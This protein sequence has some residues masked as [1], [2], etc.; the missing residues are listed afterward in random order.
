MKAGSGRLTLILLTE[1]EQ[2]WERRFW[3]PWHQDDVLTPRAL[4][5]TSYREWDEETVSFSQHHINSVRAGAK[6]S[7]H[8]RH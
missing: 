8:L 7:M 3:L 2:R 4:R 1:E 6:P 5:I